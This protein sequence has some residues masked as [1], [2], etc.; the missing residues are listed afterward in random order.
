MYCNQQTILL[1]ISHR[2]KPTA[3]QVQRNA[4]SKQCSK[5]SALW[6][7]CIEQLTEGPPRPPSRE[8]VITAVPRNHAHWRQRSDSTN[9][10]CERAK[11]RERA[12]VLR[13]RER[14]R[15]REDRATEGEGEGERTDVLRER[16]REREKKRERER[17]SGRYTTYFHPLSPTQ[18]QR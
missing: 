15:E 3:V 13:E 8:R 7:P 18:L 14:E 10:A 17:E 16:E 2:L 1:T 6:T 4:I 5:P 9:I 12:E 11:V